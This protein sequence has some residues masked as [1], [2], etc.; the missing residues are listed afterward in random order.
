MNRIIL[1]ASALLAVLQLEPGGDFVA[2]R[3]AQA[4][5]SAVNFSEVVAKLIDKGHTLA[6]ARSAVELLSLKV[7]DVDLPL[8]YAAAALRSATRQYGLSLGDRIC[9]ALGARLGAP[10]LTTDKLWAKLELGIEVTVI[11]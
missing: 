4:H 9:L 8:A 6:A 3:I 11:R 2:D 1:D 7:E 5:I 10:V